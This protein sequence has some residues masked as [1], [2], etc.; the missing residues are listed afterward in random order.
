MNILFLSASPSPSYGGVERVTHIITNA[1]SAQYKDI[2]LFGLFIHHGE[3]KDYQQYDSISYLLSS[4]LKELEGILTFIQTNK[5]DIIVNPFVSHAWIKPLF[6]SIYSNSSIKVISVMHNSPTAFELINHFHRKI[7]IPKPIETTLF[8]LYKHYLRFTL[9]SLT[10]YHVKHS[11]KYVLLS[12]QYIPVFM[13]YFGIKPSLANK[14]CSINNP[15]TFENCEGITIDK[16]EDL[17]LFVGR[18]ENISK[19]LDKIL[20]IWSKIYVNHLTWKLEIVGDGEDLSYIKEL[21]QQMKLERVSFEGHKKDPSDYY[22][23]AKVFLMTSDSEGWGMTIVEAQS[24][25]AVPVAFNTFEALQ[26]LISEN[27]QNGIIIQDRHDLEGFV[28]AVED[29]FTNY[30][31]YFN[32]CISSVEKYS[33]NSTTHKWHCMFENILSPESSQ[34]SNES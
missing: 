29:V 1:L 34:K 27:Y 15:K 13:Q 16:K 25:G 6:L 7:G 32:N 5:I 12:E 17:L 8:A 28:R 23:R 22:K 30:S 21:A 11:D 31:E 3:Q 24:N 4:D 26:E 19:R 2:N 9:K 20:E 14:I 18:I 10:R 33:N